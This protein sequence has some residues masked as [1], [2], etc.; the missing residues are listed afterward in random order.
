MTLVPTNESKEKSKNSEKLWSKITDLIRSVTKNS[1][2]YDEKF[3]TIKFNS[4]GELP[5]NKSIEK[6]DISIYFYLIKQKKK[7][8]RV[9]PFYVTNNELKKFFINNNLL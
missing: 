2:D 6:L 7:K 3:I 1:G 4:D 5:L 8:K 9:L